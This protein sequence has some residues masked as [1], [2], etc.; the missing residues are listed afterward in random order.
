M[1]GIVISY[2]RYHQYGFIQNDSGDYFFHNRDAYKGIKTG[3]E[4]S[5]DLVNDKVRGV[6]KIEG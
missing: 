4:V 5:F 1:T 3:D 2:S 6:K